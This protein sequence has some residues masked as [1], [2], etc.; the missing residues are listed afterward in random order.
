MRSRLANRL[1]CVSAAL[2]LSSL[3]VACV[4][5]EAPEVVDAP[6]IA[7]IDF[8]EFE[9]PTVGTPYVE[10]WVSPDGPQ[11]IK[12]EVPRYPARYV[13]SGYSGKVSADMTLS[14]DGSIARVEWSE[15]E[16]EGIFELNAGIALGRWR[17]NAGEDGPDRKVQVFF[18]FRGGDADWPAEAPHV[19]ACKSY[20]CNSRGP[21]YPREAREAKI[22]GNVQIRA[23]VSPDG[24]ISRQEILESPSPL[25][26]SAAM[27]GIERWRFDV[28]G[29]SCTD[30]PVIVPF[31]FSLQ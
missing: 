16:P 31:N 2:V 15:S 11:P 7:V 9:S 30:I 4:E 28:V 23:Y 5:S 19:E 29:P 10:I 12:F 27:K 1:R 3:L 22:E 20:D 24:R 8:A 6:P 14:A 13:H 26:S 21:R 17:F 18:C 25:L